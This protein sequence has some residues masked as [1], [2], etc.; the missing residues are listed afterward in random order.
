MLVAVF[1]YP[2]TV[3]Y[4]A[5]A[6]LPRYGYVANIEALQPRNHTSSDP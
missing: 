4:V 3:A 6:L 1:M 2:A 5:V